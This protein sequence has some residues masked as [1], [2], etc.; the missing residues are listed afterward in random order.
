MQVLLFIVYNVRIEIEYLFVMMTIECSNFIFTLLV[1]LYSSDAFHHYRKSIGTIPHFSLI[2]SEEVQM[3]LLLFY[4][5]QLDASIYEGTA[6]RDVLI[7]VIGTYHIH[8]YVHL[9]S[10]NYIL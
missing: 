4:I 9:I 3:F 2:K 7:N 5:R 10:D 1:Y 8:V 6:W